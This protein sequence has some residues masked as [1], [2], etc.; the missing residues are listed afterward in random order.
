MAGGSEV[1]SDIEAG[2]KERVAELRALVAYHLHRYHVL[3]APEIAD[4]E[5]DALFD[6]LLG[7]EAKHPELTSPDSPTH[8]VGAAPL[9]QFNKVSHE[10]AMLSLDKCTTEEELGDWIHRCEGRLAAG[11]RLSFFCEPKIDGVAVAL[12]YE[13]GV[14]EQAVGE[15]VGNV[16]QREVAVEAFAQIDLAGHGAGQPGRPRHDL[17]L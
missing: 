7:L 9:S 5:Y 17:G 11:E 14:L 16:E 4:A 13:Q 2:V 15:Q 6:E 8:R 10:V 3:D 1:T 12:V